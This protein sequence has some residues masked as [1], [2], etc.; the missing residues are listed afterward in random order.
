MTKN[1]ILGGVLVG[2]LALGAGIWTGNALRRDGGAEAAAKLREAQR[3]EQELVQE[4]EA[5]K[6]LAE[7]LAQLEDENRKLLAA[8]AAREAMPKMAAVTANEAVLPETAAASTLAVK[9]TLDWSR[10]AELLAAN[11]DPMLA[12]FEAE[13][14]DGDDRTSK[15]DQ[16]RLQE[17]IIEFSKL[18]QQAKEV[19]DNPILEPEIAKGLTSAIFEKTLG[20]SPGQAEALRKAVDHAVTDAKTHLE[21]PETLPSQYF[22]ARTE[23]LDG[24]TGHL[25]ASVSE[26]QKDRWSK[27]SPASQMMLRGDSSISQIGLSVNGGHPET[28]VAN[29]WQKAF[30]LNSDQDKSVRS[31]APDLVKEAQGILAKYGQTGSNPSNLSRVDRQKMNREFLMAQIRMEKR[32]AYLLTP[33]QKKSMASKMPTIFQFAP[34]GDMNTSRH[35]GPGF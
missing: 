28:E 6:A 29:R 3:A 35:R 19:S 8:S 15:E 16:A 2:V 30:S 27:L 23:L 22:L 5:K 32:F 26:A 4:R 33:E 18:A 17:V 20:L 9:K 31:M 7:R 12:S 11:I 10:F 34:G 25:D 13:K 1:A 24:I 21:G 14:E